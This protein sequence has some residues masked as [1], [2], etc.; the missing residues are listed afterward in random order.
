MSE[1]SWSGTDLGTG[2]YKGTLD[3][4]GEDLAL[5][6]HRSSP[7]W[8]PLTCLLGGILAALAGSTY[9]T[10]RRPHN[11]R[12]TA[13]DAITPPRGDLAEPVSEARRRLTDDLTKTRPSWLRRLVPWPASGHADELAR[14]DKDTERL[15][16]ASERAEDYGKALA[17]DR[18]LIATWLPGITVGAAPRSTAAE[19]ADHVEDV[20]ALPALAE[21]ATRMGGLQAAIAS[22]VESEDKAKAGAR[23][24]G[25]AAALGRLKRP[26][27]VSAVRADLDEVTALVDRLEPASAVQT[28]GAPSLTGLAIPWETIQKFLAGTGTTAMAARD[29]GVAFIIGVV[30][31]WSG[32]AALYVAAD[33]WGTLW[34]IL[35]AV[36]WGAGATAVSGPLLTSIRRI[37]STRQ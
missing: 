23:F 18:R 15:R 5:T 19:L 30:A 7:M 12:R 35:A 22:A 11:Q 26:T 14:I 9:A 29:V 37:G 24:R 20:L 4:G 27:E 21:V 34:D 32:F 17:T 6:V 10:D 31:L 16:K 2:E 1:V 33:T 25:L 28:A 13:I 3:V 8:V 36:T